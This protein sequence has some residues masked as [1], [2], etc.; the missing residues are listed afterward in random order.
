[1]S[2]CAS[3]PLSVG[4][5]MISKVAIQIDVLAFSL[6]HT[7]LHTGELESCHCFYGLS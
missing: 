4:D 3:F 2:I 5:F 7:M 1:M 6:S